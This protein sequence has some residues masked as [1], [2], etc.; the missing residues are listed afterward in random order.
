MPTSS[1]R[2]FATTLMSAFCVASLAAC[3]QSGAETAAFPE[4][5][6]DLQ[7]KPEEVERSAVFAGGC[8]WGVEAVFEHVKGV[9]DVV[10][11]YAGGTESTA[12]YRS[13][14]GGKTQHA[15]AVRIVYDPAQVSYG[16]LLK[17]F[18]A[19]AH[20]P[21][22]LNRQG[23]DVG[24]QYRS[25][26]FFAS[27]AEQRVAEKYIEQVNDAKIYRRPVVTELAP[28]QMFHPA[29]SYHQDYAARNPHE[30]YIVV[31]DAPKLRNLKR[32]LP[33]LYADR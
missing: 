22:Q 8:F 24:P 17:V 1:L 32:Q 26:I 15:E 25:A 16:Q 20:D 9:K 4:A 3:A 29:E 31:H 27:E 30:P 11:G 2:C 14:S 13:V 5:A 21:T 33:Q 12:D 18:F 19:V 10:S 28:L 23:P 6:L 7:A